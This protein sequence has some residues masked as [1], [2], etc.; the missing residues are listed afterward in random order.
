VKVSKAR[1]GTQQTI[2]LDGILSKSSL[3]KAHLF[4]SEKKS[5]FRVGLNFPYKSN[6]RSNFQNMHLVD[7]FIFL[8]P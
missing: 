5:S 4:E 7:N 3:L 1:S 8:L 2:M 6:L